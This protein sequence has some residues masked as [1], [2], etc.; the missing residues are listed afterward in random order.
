MVNGEFEIWGQ[1]LDG[2]DASVSNAPIRISAMGPDG[3]TSYGA[4][5]PA[6]TPVGTAGSFA[7]VWEGND[8]QPALDPE[9]FEVWGSIVG[10]RSIFEDGFE[11]GNTT[12]WSIT[13]P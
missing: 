11:S 1:W 7:A 5:V 9:E 4:F 13:V 8:D 2:T 12:A 10:S 6:I 3:S